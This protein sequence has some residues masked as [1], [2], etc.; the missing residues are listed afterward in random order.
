[1]RRQ[2]SAN[3]RFRENVF[4]DTG[5][6]SYEDEVRGT[7]DPYFHGL[8]H[9]APAGSGAVNG[10]RGGD[11]GLLHHPSLCD[12]RRAAEHHD[13]DGQLGCDDAAGLYGQLH[14][15][16]RQEQ[17]H[18]VFQAHG[19]LPLCYQQVRGGAQYISGPEQDL[20]CRRAVPHHR[21]LP[22][23]PHELGHH[24]QV[25][26]AAKGDHRREHHVQAGQRPYPGQHQR[27]LV[28]VPRGVRLLGPERQPDDL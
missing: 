4:C 1:M 3:S 2:R 22:R 21:A 6:R 7:T 27:I 14:A 5:G 18:R 20:Y 23:E 25:R 24:V 28:Q 8:H 19:L 12:A 11:G 16:R 17:L 15:E 26:R 9:A 10:A 13:H